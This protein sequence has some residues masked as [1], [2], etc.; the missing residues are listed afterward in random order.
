LLLGDE[1]VGCLLQACSMAWHPALLLEVEEPPRID[2]PYDHE[3]PEAGQVFLL[4]ES[5]QLFLPDDWEQRLGDSGAAFVR[6][7]AERPKALAAVRS[8]FENSLEGEHRT[9]LDLPFDKVQPFL[10]IG[11]GTWQLYALFEAMEHENL[12]A[13]SDLWK[14]VQ[15]AAKA[16][17]SGDDEECRRQ[18][19][20]AAERLQWAR[21][22]LYPTTIHV[23]DLCLDPERLPVAPFCGMPINLI[24]SSDELERLSDEQREQLRDLAR[25]ELLEPC[26]GCAL[27]REEPL[28]PIESQVWTL[29][30]GLTKARELLGKEI[31]IHGRRRA[32]AHAHLPLL[33]ATADL[34]RTVLASRDEQALPSFRATV[35]SWPAP[36]GRQVE[37]FARPPFRADSPQFFAHLGHYAHQT[38][39]RDHAATLALVHDG[40]PAACW[41]QDWLELTRMSPV[42]GGWI[43]LSRYFNEVYA[44]EHLSAQSPDEFHVDYL[45]QRTEAHNVQPATWFAWHQRYRRRLDGVFTLAAVQCALGVALPD[46][47]TC[48]AD[49]LETRLESCRLPSEWKDRE[50]LDELERATAAALAERLLARAAD[51]QAGWVVLNPC[52]FARRVALELDGLRSP[53]PCEGPLKAFQLDGDKGRMVVEVPPLGFAWVPRLENQAPPPSGR[54]KLADERHVRNEFFEAEIDLATGGLR[55]IWDHKT[56]LSRLAQQIVFNPGSTMKCSNLIVVS[57]GPAL[58]EVVTEGLIVGEQ[59]QTL[60]RYRQRFRAWLGRPL[61]ELRIEIYPELSP[62]GYPWHAYYGARFAWREERAILL[63]G[64]LGTGY[65]ATPTRLTA[66]DYLELRL[67][68]GNTVI[69]PGGLPF[70]QRHGGRMLDVILMPEHEGARVFELAVALDRPNPMLTAQG[71]VS[72]APVVAVAKGPPHVGAA[73]WLFHLDS[74]NAMLTSLR[75]DAEGKDAIVARVLE[76]GQHGGQVELRCVRDPVRAYLID[77]RGQIQSE[78]SVH[79]DAV[80]FELMPGD[81][82]Q[83]RIEFS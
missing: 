68:G 52:G 15:A 47:F 3:N 81:F 54:V 65:I 41:Y 14:D 7:P 4:P 53:Q 76:C 9:L 38:I 21:E 26:G 44:N 46:D 12:V 33:L 28:L 30:A 6:V 22:A 27:E 11:Y 74:P 2:P 69:F 71:L 19:Q 82:V 34:R 63:R 48:R 16:L 36:N 60:A 50:T 58:G 56:R 25:R 67:G 61:L 13:G 79:G 78:A 18:L 72:P 35:V 40:K 80:S 5:P 10:A 23:V 73:G 29:S 77:S 31:S 43:L 66:P 32:G 37:A 83:L 55:G 51:G 24:V 20:S 49:D 1:D 59:D 42:F 39:A 8:A 64:V 75:P 17:M 57:T 70:H 62:S 45:S